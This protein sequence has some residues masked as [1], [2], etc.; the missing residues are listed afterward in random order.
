MD[1]SGR[2]SDQLRVLGRSLRERSPRPVPIL[3]SIALAHQLTLSLCMVVGAVLIGGAQIERPGL[4]AAGDASIHALTAV[5]VVG[6]LLQRSA[7]TVAPGLWSRLLVLI[8]VLDL[9]VLGVSRWAALDSPGLRGSLM[10][11]PAVW[12][13]AQLR[14]RGALIGIGMSLLSLGVGPLLAT[15]EHTLTVLSRGIS[16]TLLVGALGAVVAA[17]TTQLDETSRRNAL[18]ADAIGAVEVV[19]DAD[20]TLR[21]RG[22]LRGPGAG[23]PIQELLAGPLMTENGR[24]PVPP[25]RTPLARV[26][27]GAELD[28]QA[29]WTRAGEHRIALSVS[30]T[31]LDEERMLMVVHDVTTSLA[32]VLQEE[33]FLAGISHELKTPLTSIAGYVELLEDE[34]EGARAV[35]A[36]VVRG[37][38]AVIA[39]NVERLRSLILGLLETA[40]TSTDPIGGA[41]AP[42]RRTSLTR[43]VREQIEAASPRAAG[44]GLR[45][46]LEGLEEEVELVNA[47]PERL[48]QAIDN[49]LAN[50]IAYSHEG[51]TITVS[52]RAEAGRAR[53]TVRDEGI[54]ID[55]EDLE[56][57]F[58]PYFRARSA[59]RAGIEGNGLGLM[60]TRRIA[61]A[62]G[63]EVEV[64]STLGEGTAVTF[65]LP[66]ART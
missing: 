36:A 38:L 32:A 41:G 47:D 35:D 46:R 15:P 11:L 55:A 51:G 13:A 1:A 65:V 14:L 10:A 26:R 61:R 40:R 58:A 66:L 27:A 30:S 42:Q 64:A 24:S 2:F 59:T 62:H 8:P 39:R 19:V 12:L 54:G 17:I 56:S 29:V 44:R 9:L 34:A 33:Q 22:R 16:T 4:Y 52:L 21:S 53:C 25:E 5:V 3:A 6:T 20:G 50:A 7:G 18:I 23:I 60:I 48:G 43:L 45:W 37:H 31:R 57:L 63:G 28:G 49:L